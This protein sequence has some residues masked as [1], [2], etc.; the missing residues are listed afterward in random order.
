MSDAQA[1]PQLYFIRHGETE[2]SLSGQ[3]TGRTD[4][5]LTEHGKE[6]ARALVPWLHNISFSSVITSPRQRA[7]ATCA[8][9]G[10]G[11][12]AEIDEDLC[13]WEY[14]DYEGQLSADIIKQQPGWAIF[15]D[16]CP[17]GETPTAISDRADRL[18]TRLLTLR[19][20]VALFSHGQFGT[21]LATRWIGLKVIEGQ[22]L[23]LSPASLS[24]L[25]NNPSHPSVRT[26]SLWN[27]GS[28]YLTRK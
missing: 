5:P 24:I 15:R 18:I 26:I 14:G 27:V 7:Q 28:V 21:V 4:I 8:L 6:E 1:C 16:G 12:M 23:L 3:H 19:G 9:A 22:H 17:N 25:G 2:W 20:N 13:E 11:N 10:L